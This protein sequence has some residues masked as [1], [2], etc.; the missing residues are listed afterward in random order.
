MAYQ[1]QTPSDPRANPQQ[2]QKQNTCVCERCGFL[3]KTIKNTAVSLWTFCFFN[4]K[5]VFAAFSQKSSL[6]LVKTKVFQFFLFGKFPPPPSIKAKCEFWIQHDAV[7]RHQ[8]M[9][10]LQGAG[11][12]KACPTPYNSFFIF[13]VPVPSARCQSLH[14]PVFIFFVCGYQPWRMGIHIGFITGVPQQAQS[15]GWQC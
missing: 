15:F 11:M 9:R 7:N 3:P 5:K 4:V 14:F 8:L 13:S 10:I 1:D 2:K 12:G 6:P